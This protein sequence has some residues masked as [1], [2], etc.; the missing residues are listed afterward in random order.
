M[1]TPFALWDL[2]RTLI[3]LEIDIEDV[4]RWKTKIKARLAPLGWDGWL[5]PMLPT[6]ENAL[7]TLQET[8]GERVAG[9]RA[10]LYRN[11]DDWEAQALQGLTPI[12]HGIEHLCALAERDTPLA[13]VTNNGKPAA[14]KALR[15]LD[16]YAA[17]QGWTPPSWRAQVFRTHHRPSKPAPDMLAFALQTMGYDG[18]SPALMFGDSDSDRFSAQALAGSGVPIK[19]VDVRSLPL[20]S[21]GGWVR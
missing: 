14:D 9:L 15:A 5:S 11:L 7:D 8:H 1:T 3:R 12:H 6:L 21:T 16:E 18:H 19:F 10:D 13:L 20:Q 4:K 17:S 2:D